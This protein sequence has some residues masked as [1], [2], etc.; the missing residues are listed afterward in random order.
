MSLLPYLLIKSLRKSCLIFST[1][2]RHSTELCTHIF[3]KTSGEGILS[4]DFPA[5][6]IEMKLLS[7][8][9]NDSCGS[10]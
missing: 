4:V 2:M 5:V 1:Y 6:Y 3:K 10:K 9:I 7:H 8:V